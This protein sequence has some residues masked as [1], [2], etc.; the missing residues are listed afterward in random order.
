MM[1][2][3]EKITRTI[4]DINKQ[5]NKPADRPTC[6]YYFIIISFIIIIRNFSLSL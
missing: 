2:R 1:V 5:T 6:L 4:K 3:D